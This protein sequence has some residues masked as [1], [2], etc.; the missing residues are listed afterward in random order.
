MFVITLIYLVYLAAPIALL[1]VGSFGA[2]WT[3]TLLPSGF[4]DRWYM[5]VFT[6]PSF[7][8]A[9]TTSLQVV[10]ATC[11]INAVLGVPLAYAIFAAAHRG[12]Q[13]AARIM[14][15]LPIAVPELVL[16]FGFILV[17]SSDTL[18][19]LGS[20][21]LLIAAHVVVTLPYLL[22]TLLADMRHLGLG[23]M[24]RVAD[25]LG[26]SFANRFFDIVLPSLRYSLLSGLIMVAAIS[27][28]E[29]QISNLVAGFLSRTYPVVLL[30][31]FY[32]ATG[33]AC[34]ATVVLLVLA[35]VAAGGGALAARAGHAR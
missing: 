7:Q 18:P 16:A 32:G 28:G 1:F 35:F 20:V 17:F 23:E 14:S 6:D 24:E 5:E 33:F 3:N 8:R 31:A 21:W 12:V 29:F 34:A 4:T 27:I 11:L 13:V 9:F 30:Q 26:A 19:F 15:L 25:T 22:N 10:G 2:S